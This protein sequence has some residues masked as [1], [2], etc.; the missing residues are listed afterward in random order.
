MEW[1]KAE[2]EKMDSNLY[3]KKFKYEYYWSKKHSGRYEIVFSVGKKIIFWI[4][5]TFDG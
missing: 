4:N 2:K 3:S 1:M 5:P